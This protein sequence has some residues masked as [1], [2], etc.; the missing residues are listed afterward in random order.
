MKKQTNLKKINK[1]RILGKHFERI[2]VVNNTDMNK[3]IVLNCP[4]KVMVQELLNY[5]LQ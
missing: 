4:Y 1:D 3:A 2:Y 5:Q